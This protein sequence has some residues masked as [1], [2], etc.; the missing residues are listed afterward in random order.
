MIEAVR[1]GMDLKKIKIKK[2]LEKALIKITSFLIKSFF[3]NVNNQLNTSN[4]FI[5]Q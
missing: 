3:T 5:F 4:S 1:F 2:N